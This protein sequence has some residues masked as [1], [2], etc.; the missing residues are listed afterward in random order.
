MHSSIRLFVRAFSALVLVTF[1]PVAHAALQVEAEINPNPVRLDEMV[2]VEFTVVN[3]GGSPE[4]NVTL[5]STVPAEFNSLPENQDARDWI[6][7]GGNCN[8][9]NCDPGELITW[10]LG[11]L[12]ADQAVTVAYWTTINNTT[13]DATVINVS[14]TVIDGGLNEDDTTTESTTVV[15]S[16][17]LALLI[18]DDAAPVESGDSLT[19]TLTYGNHGVTSVSANTLTLPL[20]AGTSFVSATNGG[21][22]SAG[23]VS[24][25]LGTLAAGASG[26]V[27][28][29]VTVNGSAGDLLIVDSA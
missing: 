15:T 13:A 11:T 25:N 2:R 10:N 29:T 5:Q 1:L 4:S 8:S 28:A 3:T 27:Q 18:E 20:P 26:Q 17:Q 9:T 14:A 19:Y 6:T 16:Q 24:W 22:E 12:A 23:V 21:S 7:G